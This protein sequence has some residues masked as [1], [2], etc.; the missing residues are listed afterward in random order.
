MANVAAPISTRLSTSNRLRPTRSPKCPNTRPPIGR[1]PK[2]IAYV[3]NASR[4]PV[5]GSAVGKKSLLNT[6][7]AAE[8]YRKKSYHSIV[9]PTRLAPTTLTSFRFMGKEN[10]NLRISGDGSV[11]GPAAVDRKRRAGQRGRVLAAQ[12]QHQRGHLLWL[13]Q[14]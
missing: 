12:P 7:A 13:D 6:S 14:P 11:R 4:V 5:S 3:R 2:P 1:A 9:V 8:L 10:H